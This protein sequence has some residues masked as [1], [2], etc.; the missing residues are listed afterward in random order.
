[1]TVTDIYAAQLTVL[2]DGRLMLGTE[3]LP[4]NVSEAIRAHIHYGDGSLPPHVGVRDLPGGGKQIWR[5]E[6]GAQA[7]MTWEPT[8]EHAM[9]DDEMRRVDLLI[10]REIESNPD[11]PRPEEARLKQ[12]RIHVWAIAGSLTPDGSNR[13]AVADAYDV[14]P[15][16]VLAAQWYYLRHRDRFNARLRANTF[17]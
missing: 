6:D 1:M 15:D 4:R 14:S 7:A 8:P 11:D 5:I 2:P 12:R 16:A 3:E 13:A 10:A 17:G 9:T